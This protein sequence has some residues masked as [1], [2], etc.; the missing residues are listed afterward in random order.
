MD[1]AQLSELTQDRQSIA[2]LVSLIPGGNGTNIYD[3]LFDASSYLRSKA[4]DRRRAII[5][6][7]DNSQSVDSAHSDRDTLQELLEASTI[8]Y[9]IE[10]RGDNPG[11][12]AYGSLGRIARIARETGGELLKAGTANSLVEA[13]DSALLNLKAGY[14][15]GFAPSSLG[16]EGS[17]HRLQ[18]VLNAAGSCPKCLVQARAGY[19]AG[20]RVG[21]DAGTPP[22]PWAAGRSPGSVRSSS[23]SAFNRPAEMEEV[24][25]QHAIVT[26][27][28]RR[29][30][31]R[32][33]A[34]EV[35]VAEEK[36]AGGKPQAKIDLRIDA[37][38]VMFRFA[39]GRYV[40]RLRITAFYMDPKGKSLGADWKIMDLRL[41][42]PTYQQMLQSGI[43]YSTT[44]PVKDPGQRIKVVVYDPGSA[45]LGSRFVQM[46]RG[47]YL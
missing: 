21:T 9:S 6:I 40:G 31:P 27:R 16:E 38:N 45:R 26:A 1:V 18:V 29:V 32:D 11:G 17:Y 39:G 20:A 24:I 34:F 25:A 8:L 42:E 10:T 36:D 30:E 47:P 44:I 13:L 7:S 23:G 4:S 22:P 37:A 2:R 14:V 43:P 33:I 46:N 15:L 28:D 19:Y 35:S 12:A 41:T 5:L 3:A